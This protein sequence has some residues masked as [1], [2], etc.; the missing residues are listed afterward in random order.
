MS[1]STLNPDAHV[2]VRTGE[3]HLSEAPQQQL[4]RRTRPVQEDL[5]D[6]RHRHLQHPQQAD[7]QVEAGGAHLGAG[8]AVNTGVT[9]TRSINQSINQIR[10][11]STDLQLTSVHK[12]PL[13]TFCRLL[14]LRQRTEDTSQNPRFD[15]VLIRHRCVFLQNM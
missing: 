8:S 12:V 14:D 6:Q 2:R 9:R 5:W 15:R 1:H 7:G 10:R 4:C 3:T 11:L 13:W